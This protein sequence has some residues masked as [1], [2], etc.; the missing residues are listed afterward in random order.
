[1]ELMTYIQAVFRRYAEERGHYPP[2][3]QECREQLRRETEQEE[4]QAQVRHNLNIY[5]LT[6]SISDL[7]SDDGEGGHS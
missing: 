4:A 6:G 7:I 2:S 5:S 1:M 3:A